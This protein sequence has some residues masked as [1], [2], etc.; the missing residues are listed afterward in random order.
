MKIA[1]ELVT[2]TR[3]HH[4]SLSLSNRCVNLAK[5]KDKTNINA[6][7]LAISHHFETTF[8]SH[9]ETEEQTLFTPLKNKSG[10][11]NNLCEQ[12]EKEHQQ[13]LQ[14]AKS[15][16]TNPELLLGLAIY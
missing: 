13:L 10:A 8:K 7:C 12:L 14:M 11:L 15:L 16:K 6:L 2:L 9:F 1:P 4:I 3:E 5:I